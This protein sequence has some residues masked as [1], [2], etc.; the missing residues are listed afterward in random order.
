MKAVFKNYRMLDGSQRQMLKQVGSGNIIRLF[1]KTLYPRKDTDVVCPHFME[2]V[3]VYGCPYNCSYCYIKGTFRFFQQQNGRIPLRFKKEKEVVRSIRTFLSSGLP[4]TILNTGEL[5][6][7]LAAEAAVFYGKPFSEYIMPF[8]EGTKHKVLF[9]SKGTNVK[10]FLKHEWQKN[11]ILSWTINAYPVAKRWE[12][13]AP[14]PR[15]RIAAAKKVAEAGYEVRVRIDPMVA[16][17]DYAVHYQKLVDDLFEAF[18]PLRITLGCLRGLTSTMARAVDKSWIP[19]LT[20]RS[21]WG[22][23]PP[24]ETRY[25]LYGN[26]LNKLRELGYPELREHVGVC[27]DT[28]EV[29]AMLKKE[30]GLDWQKLKCNC[31]V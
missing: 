17:K 30:F 7:S 12:K 8:F 25:G 21:S 20:E 19:Y 13:L 18:T 5:T 4:P 10:N 16:V 1:D 3:C 26:I 29:W 31:I 28:L 24:I 23:K 22:R 9:L 6:D 15:A 14:H 2:L 11:T 27:K